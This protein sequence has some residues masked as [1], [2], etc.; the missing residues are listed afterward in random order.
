MKLR[1][2]KTIVADESNSSFP[3]LSARMMSLKILSEDLPHWCR[4]TKNTCEITCKVD[5]KARDKKGYEYS[6]LANNVM[7]ML[8]NDDL[9]ARANYL[10]GV[11]AQQKKK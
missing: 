8:T 1:N 7:A 2:Q 9:N 6:I 4:W 11:Y 10:E 5:T 3:S